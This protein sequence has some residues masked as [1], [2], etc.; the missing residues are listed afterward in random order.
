MAADIKRVQYLGGWGSYHFSYCI[1]EIHAPL[2][3]G[4][5]YEVI[6]TRPLPTYGLPETIYTLKVGD[7]T[8]D[9][10][11]AWFKMV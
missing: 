7:T 11:S 1:G 10:N 9:A 2:V 8:V 3:K 4:G 6:K 5:I